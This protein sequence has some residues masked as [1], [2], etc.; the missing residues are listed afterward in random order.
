MK[1]ISTLLLLLF[2]LFSGYCFSQQTGDDQSSETASPKKL[3]KE[4]DQSWKGFHAG[5]YLGGFF[6]NNYTAALY[7]GYGY[8]QDGNP[9]DFGNS[10]MY[11]R[12]M[13]DYGGNYGQTIDQ[14]ALALGVNHGDWMFDQS[15][16]PAS[17]TYN[18]AFMIGAHLQ[19]GITKKDGIILNVNTA[20]LN[21]TGNFTIVLTNPLIGPQQPGYQNIKTFAIT[22]GEQRMMFQLGYRRVLGND[23]KFNFFIEGGP[24]F[25]LTK[26]MKNQITINN[27]QIDLTYYYN[28]TYYTTYHAKYLIG[29]GFGAFAGFG[30][31]FKMN[32]KISLEVVYTPSYEKISIGYEPKYTLQNAI[33]AKIFYDL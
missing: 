17:V 26:F 12:I 8:D 28:Q 32:P 10:F 19:Y 2:V 4:K 15:D 16:M 31:N 14:V 5:L 11:R 22:G 7:N 29:V 13:I 18:T 33:G 25:N 6:A 24:A 20:Q 27:L 30:F 21:L 1:L 9:N 3:K 23:D